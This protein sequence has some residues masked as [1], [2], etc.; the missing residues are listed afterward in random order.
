M[1]QESASQ[2]RADRHHQM[3]PTLTPDEIAR[4]TRFGT[5]QRFE[6][7][8][9]LVRAGQRAPGMV[10][11]LGGRVRLSQRNGLGEVVPIIENGPGQFLG[12]VGQLSGAA[13]LVDAEVLEDLEALVIPTEQLRALIIGEA[14]LGERI[15]RAL[16]LRR[17]GLIEAGIS[18]PVLVGS[19]ESPAIVRLQ[20]FLRRN[21][22]PHQQIQASECSA[23][24]TLLEQYGVAADDAMVVCPNGAVLVNP[25]EAQLAR[26]IGMLDMREREELF[27]VI[28]VG[29]GPAGLAAAVYAASEGLSVV[30]LDCRHFGGQAGA[31]ARIENYLGFPTGISGMAL[32]GRAFVQAQKFGVD[33]MIPTEALALDCSQAGPEGQLRLQMSDGRWLRGRTVVV[34]SGAR[35][36]RPEVPRLAE[37]E[38]RG[39]W[40]W[41]SAVEA[42]LC[43]QSEVALVGGGNSAGQ[44]AVFLAEHAAKVHMLVRG[45]D[46]SASMSRYLID[47]IANTSNIEL[48]THTELSALHGER[49][50]KLNGLSWRDRRSGEQWDCDTRNLFLFVGAEPETRWLE[51]CGVAVDAHGFVCTGA[52]AEAAAGAYLPGPLETSVPGVF[53][54][55]DV[56]SGSVK[57]VG[58]AIGEGAAAVASIHQY[59]AGA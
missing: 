10:V 7:G 38:G 11:Q 34:A 35:Y 36:R 44:A 22:Q 26:C 31:S 41:A 58:G 9:F 15:T 45:P 53:A 33:V 20:G 50:G 13:A 25:S 5:V 8:H 21:G 52:A 57:R 47:R 12:E 49:G 3:F 24:A 48:L 27:D 55:G 29:A 46:L 17:V 28:I 23:T 43:A 40:Y 2:M 19:P 37:F 32:A 18:G 4:I 42:K 14:D 6:R 1:S 51:G 59:L 54:V 30:V 16:I 39:V 56:R